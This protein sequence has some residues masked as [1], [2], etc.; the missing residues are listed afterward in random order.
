MTIDR[1]VLWLRIAG[2]LFTLWA[3][4]DDL[5]KII[6]R[7]LPFAT[8]AVTYLAIMCCLWWPRLGVIG[9]WLAFGFAIG[10]GHYAM[11]FFAGP[12]MIVAISITRR[13]GYI[14]AGLLGWLLV[15]LRTADLTRGF[16][17]W[18]MTPVLVFLSGLGMV[19]GHVVTRKLDTV[20]AV[21]EAVALFEE[22]TR[23]QHL[24]LAGRLH[25]EI[26]HAFASAALA[27]SAAEATNLDTESL[28]EVR[29]A[30]AEGGKRLAEL[31]A[32]LRDE[33]PDIETTISH[34][35]ET[36]A[37]MESVLASCGFKIKVDPAARLDRYPELV[38]PLFNR[39]LLEATTNALKHGDPR[40]V[41]T[42]E[43]V[44]EPDAFELIVQNGCRSKSGP[45]QGHGLSGL[46]NLARR[47][48]AAIAWQ[49]LDHRWRIR[50]VGDLDEVIDEGF[51]VDFS[52][53]AVP[54][55]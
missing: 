7:P 55:L 33:S 28:H 31:V 19:V 48:N 51:R 15:G 45:A 37:K 52:P 42:Y 39:F 21:R 36:L 2:T 29:L 30:C 8:V 44:L 47:L 14:A 3:A 50:L 9:F 54:E 10:S 40:H 17:L 4:A 49:T 46:A 24:V 26:G 18:I 25:D 1:G 22:E 38:H 53:D 35:T 16:T 27:T 43:F 5:Y 20:K 11:L 34:P 6:D 12:V 32:F 13:W 41:V 23:R